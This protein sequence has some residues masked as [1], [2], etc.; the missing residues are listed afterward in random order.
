[1]AMSPRDALATISRAVPELR[2]TFDEHIILQECVKT[3]Y[4]VVERE[5]WQKIPPPNVPQGENPE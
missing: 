5:E 1:M 2:L 4:G 3:L